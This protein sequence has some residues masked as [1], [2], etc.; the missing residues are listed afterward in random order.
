LFLHKLGGQDELAAFL[1]RVMAM[2][3]RCGDHPHHRRRLASR[4]C[5]RTA[6]APARA[7]AWPLQRLACTPTAASRMRISSG[8]GGSHAQQPAAAPRPH[9]VG[10]T[11]PACMRSCVQA[12]MR[13]APNASRCFLRSWNNPIVSSATVARPHQILAPAWQ[14]LD[15]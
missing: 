10:C 14:V 6:V 5:V 12:C 11:W 1:N 4:P 8:S 2:D 7:P 15:L 13:Y 3:P 9:A